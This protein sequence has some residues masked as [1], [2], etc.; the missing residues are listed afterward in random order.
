LHDVENDEHLVKTL[1]MSG[2]VH[3]HVTGYDKKHKIRS[4]LFWDV[5]QLDWYQ[6]MLRN[7]PKEQ[8]PHLHCSGS[9][10]SCKA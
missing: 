8:R 3:F 9:W 10:K 6:S 5:M 7:I 4:L 2:K 1:L